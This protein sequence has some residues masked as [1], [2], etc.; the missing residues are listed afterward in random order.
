MVLGAGIGRKPS[1][2]IYRNV[3]LSASSHRLNYGALVSADGK[4]RH[5]SANAGYRLPFAQVSASFGSNNRG[6]RQLS[7]RIGGAL[8]AH[9]YGVTAVPELSETFAVVHVPGGAGVHAGSSRQP[10]DYFGNGIVSGLTAYRYNRIVLDGRPLKNRIEINESVR[11]IVPRRY[12]VPVLPFS[13]VS[14][15]PLMLVLAPGSVMPPLGAEVYDQGRRVGYVVQG[16]RIWVRGIAQEGS[17]EAVWGTEAAQRCRIAYR[18]QDTR[19]D[20]PAIARYPAVCR[21]ADAS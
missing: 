19:A 13:A 7:Y 16:N 3:S 15:R 8:V 11:R 9:P 1:N 21:T 5:Y 10:L 6:N 20:S 18:L 14:G 12:L 17:L 4:S 2:E